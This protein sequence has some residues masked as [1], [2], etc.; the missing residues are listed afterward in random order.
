MFQ[1]VNREEG[2]EDEEFHRLARLPPGRHGLPR[3]FVARNQRDRLAA[4]IIATVAEHGYHDAT[5]SQIAAAAGVSRRT[6][7]TYFASKE[8]CFNATYD[9][10]VQELARLG[11]EA[12]EGSTSWPEKVRAKL[13]AILEAFAANTDLVRFLVIAPERAGE[14]L[15][16]NQREAMEFAA[17]EILDG[18]PPSARK[19]SKAT[20][21]AIGGGIASLIARQVE[22]GEGE[23]LPEFLPQLLELALTPYIGREEAVRVARPTP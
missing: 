8:E 20:E 7:Y 4:G 1:P 23:G 19:L 21:L 16:G 10:V 3:E 11:R 9:M 5:I 17:N 13:G 6:F 2:K 18:I 12:G 15:A 22:A 14:E